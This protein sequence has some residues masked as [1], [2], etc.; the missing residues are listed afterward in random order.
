MDFL[1][2]ANP[3]NADEWIS[4]AQ[5]Q[6]SDVTRGL[7]EIQPGLLEFLMSADEGI[8]NSVRSSLCGA[9][10]PTTHASWVNSISCSIF[11]RFLA[12]LNRLPSN[13]YLVDRSIDEACRKVMPYMV[14]LSA[15]GRVQF[16]STDLEEPTNQKREARITTCP[17]QNTSAVN[18]QLF[19]VLGLQY[20]TSPKE[21]QEVETLL[22]QRLEMFLGLLID[23]FGNPKL[24]VHSKTLIFDT[25]QEINQQSNLPITA[26]SSN[27]KLKNQIVEG[28]GILD[29]VAQIG[30]KPAFTVISS[31]DP[32]STVGERNLLSRSPETDWETTGRNLFDKRHYSQAMICFEKANLPMERGIAAAYESRKQAKLLQAAQTIDQTACSAAFTKAATDFLGCAKLTKGEQQVACYL[33]AAEC[34]LQAEDWITAAQAYR[35]ANDFDMAARIFLGEGSIDKAVEVVKEHRDD[36]LE[37]ITEEIIGIARLE[38]FRTNQLERASELFDEVDEQLEYM[39][40]YGF[41]VA[42]IPVLEHRKCHDRARKTIEQALRGLWKLFPF[43]SRGTERQIPAID[44]FINQLSNSKTLKCEESRELEVFQALCTNDAEK[45][46]ALAQ[47]SEEAISDSGQ[48]A[49]SC[50]I[51]AL[52]CFSHSSHLLIPQRNSTIS[53][54]IQKAK[55]AL[56]YINHLLQFTR[57][58]DVSSLNAQKLLGFEPLE[59]T[60][61]KENKLP[62]FW[63]HSTSLMFEGAQKILDVSEVPTSSTLGLF[64]LAASEADTRHLALAAMYDSIRSEVRK[65]HQAA[66]LGSYLYPC[67]EFAICGR[68]SLSECGRQEVFSHDLPNE[69]RQDFFNQRARGLI[70]QIQIVHGY[71]VDSHHNEHERRGFRRTWAR[72]LYENLMPHFPPLGNFLC[73]DPKRIPELA[74]S[75][76]AISAW[77]KDALHNLDPGF[78]PPN[79]FLSDVL[80]YLDISFRINRQ[81][82]ILELHSRKLV[83]P[84]DD[85]MIAKVGSVSERYSIVHDFINF[86]A[87]RSPDVISRAIRA[88]HHIIFEP[89]AVEANVLVNVL[90]FVGREIILQWR[91]HQS[92]SD[93]V[94]DK[95]MVPRSWAVDLIKSSPLPAQQGIH[96]RDFF[97]VL[98]K[99]LEGFRCFEPG[100][101][102]L[103]AFNGLLGLRV[104]SVLIMRICRL[105]VLIAH[106]TSIP[107]PVK[108]EIRQAIARSLGGPGEVLTSLCSRFL[109]ADSWTGLL[110]AVRCSPLNRGA[111]ELVYSFRHREGKSPPTITLIRTIIYNDINP[112]LATLLSLVEPDATP[113][114]KS[115]PSVHQA[116]EYLYTDT[117]IA[118]IELTQTKTASGANVSKSPNLI[119]SESNFPSAPQIEPK[120][121]L[122]TSEIKSGKKIIPCYKRYR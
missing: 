47:S 89:L 59:S 95:L 63:I 23:A 80:A 58:L 61:P 101:S 26:D 116:Q 32:T 74:H 107:L 45:L 120:R 97:D 39:E 76:N 83:R 25:P 122:T 35:A 1:K 60:E 77:C 67:L 3:S 113:D 53:E 42:L 24:G 10:F 90:E 88:A 7:A 72:R 104:R 17:Y 62:E 79:R 93:G 99:V 103:Y 11:Q 6:F 12:Y 46:L 37:N 117:E 55:L 118:T 49:S 8:R 43:N 56:S 22:L 66:S 69:Q 29:H 36:M 21:L 70:I 102:P 38:Y 106:N 96:L 54:F 40:N 73:I 27:E 109:R 48:S 65:M 64:S 91:I 18:P 51:L 50:S 34:Y 44:L 94:F 28:P 20:P 121:S 19:S 68:C 98:Y 57:S 110:N 112:E 16:P 52:L 75:I 33:H 105:I 84:R 5:T 100:S 13:L 15:L 9:A 108:E 81:D 111:D 115:E 14:L 4:F 114:P 71:Q 78:G 82:Y 41:A 31:L 119:R 85:L 86:Y 30:S 87:R 92:G 2:D